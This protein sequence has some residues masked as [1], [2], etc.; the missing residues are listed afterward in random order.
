M[1]G[2][3]VGKNSA[4]SVAEADAD[5]VARAQA[6]DSTAMHD[7]L[8]ALRPAITRYCHFRL[9]SYAGGRDAADDAVQETCLAVA[10]VIGS[11]SDQG[12]PFRAWVYAIAANK[13]TDSQRRFGRSD[14]LVDELPEQVE[15]SLTP[16]EAAIAAAEYHA[17]LALVDRL[18]SRMRDV[19]LLRAGGATAKRVGE[20]L[21]MSPGAVNVAHHRAVARL[22]DL[23]E[24]SEELRELFGS[25]RRPAAGTALSQVA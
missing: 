24:E 23:V 7:L 2:Y 25:L 8:A 16:E 6:G 1:G 10:S 22:R 5:L 19:V 11:F 15:P 12:I 18:P 3:L 17:A 21:E 9:S 20:V 13:V 4:T 14:V